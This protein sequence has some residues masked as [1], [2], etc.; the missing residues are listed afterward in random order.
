MGKKA[1]KLVLIDGNAIIHR[2]FHAMPPLTTKKGELVNAVYG[3]TTTLLN[4]ISK[5]RPD[6]IIATFDLAGPTFRH[7]EYKDYKA[8][9]TKAPDEL[10]LQIPRVKEIV[11]AFNIPI[12]EKEGFEADDVIGTVVKQAE[13]NPPP[14]GIENIIVTGDLDTL[15]LVSDQTFVY[16]MRRG[17]TDSVL[18][19]E[20]SVFERYGLKPEQ[21]ID[22]KGLR[23]DPS[24]N[25]LGVKGIGE[26]TACELLKKY[27][28]L[29]SI[30]KNLGEIKG[31]TKEKLERDKMQAI[32]SKQLATIKLDVP[33][34]LDFDAAKTHDFDREKLIELLRNLEFFSLIKRLPGTDSNPREKNEFR[35]DKAIKKS[36]CE[37]VEGKKLE[38]IAKE[39]AEKKEIAIRIKT[40]GE[41]IL[42]KEAQGIAFSVVSGKSYYVPISRENMPFLREILED[43]KIKKIGYDLKGDL[44]TLKNH[45][46]N[47]RGLGADVLL[48]AYVLNPGSKIEL[49]NLVLEELGEEIIEEKKKGQLGLEI[50]SAQEAAQ[51]VCQMAEYFLALEKIY[52]EKIEAIAKN[53][54]TEGNL[55]KVF[56]NL[57]MPLIKVLAGMETWGIK[58]NTVIFRG[59]AEKINKRIKNLEKAIYELAGKDFNINSSRQLADILFVDLGISNADI[60]KGKTGYSTASAE[61]QKIKDKHKI[62]EKIEE[63]REIFKLKSTYLDALPLLVD[64]HSRIH[65]SFNQA[66]TATGR[67]SSS[68]PNLQNIPIR[69]DIGQLLR[70]AFEAEEGWKLVAA[71]YSQIDLRVVAHMSEDKKMIELFHGGVDIHRATA[72]EV[73]KVSLSQVTEKMRRSAKALNFGVIYGMSVFGFS[74][75]ANINRDEAK[76]FI[77]E[78]FNRFPGVA[79][80]I[81]KTK[82]FAKKNQYVE[83]EIGR[84]RILP[85]INSPNFMVA[86]AAERMAINM[87]IQ[88]LSADIVKIAML[89]IYEEYENNPD[90]RM[91]LQIHDE[92]I[93]ETKEKVAGAVAKKVKDIMES[94]Y[95]LR[96]PLLVDV[97]IGD[98]WGEI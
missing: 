85:E 95:N 49:S 24:D 58:L 11:R 28:S 32:Q 64:E 8:T 92:I 71:D 79:D 22:F 47:L 29:E 86:N 1:K 84:R 50:E 97:K 30:Y 17:L 12:L 15:Q 7:I 41:N 10:Y 80:Y 42:K 27:G 40:I 9:R 57:E 6:Y 16:T 78:Y 74:Q 45:G 19:D 23:G 70:T 5:F 88:G 33:V 81:R 77:D 76:K 87:P 65:T 4:V 60:K 55:K 43:S 34:K 72:A 44:E 89:K 91:I 39:I 48:A 46:I 35:N 66:V 20:D 83:T 61:L 14:D 36:T 54:K 25:I 94:A 98:N 90:V 26:K 13:K 31:A 52:R 62:V 63:Y 93:L 38:K 51:K 21:L 37:I 75:A 2:S 82:E 59:I 67:L 53:Q 96:V 3:F 68:E 18:Y 73:Y 56:E 69:T